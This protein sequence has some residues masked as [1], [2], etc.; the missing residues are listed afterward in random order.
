MGP[1]ANARG[2][3]LEAPSAKGTAIKVAKA[4]NFKQAVADAARKRRSI[5]PL[6]KWAKER[7]HLPPT[8][9]TIHNLVTTS[10]IATTPSEKALALKS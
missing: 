1:C 2:A 8:P 10:G 9:P 4:V 6:A 7:S 5:W 3:Y